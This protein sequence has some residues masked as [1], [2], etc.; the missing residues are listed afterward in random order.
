MIKIK[1]KSKN[2]IVA[3]EGRKKVGYLNFGY[4]ADASRGR[5]IG[6][7]YMYV[8]PEFRRKGIGSKMLNFLIINKPKAVWLSLWTGKEIEKLKAAD[9][10][11][12]NGFK[13]LAHQED[14]YEKGVGVTLFAKKISK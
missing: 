4:A 14:Y 3:L 13:K 9:F 6:I 7:S 2:K 10:Y 1:F 12:K 5:N 11:L 8:R